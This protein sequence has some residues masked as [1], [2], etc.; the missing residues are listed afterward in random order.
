[1]ALSGAYRLPQMEAYREL[2]IQSVVRYRIDPPP[3][4]WRSE[5]DG[6]RSAYNS[7]TGL[8][9]R[10]GDEAIE[11]RGFGPFR[12]LVGLFGAKLSLPT[13]DTTMWTAHPARVGIGG[14]RPPWPQ[15]DYLA[16]SYTLPTDS[17][18][19]LAVCPYRGQLD[20]LRDA[21]KAA[22]VKES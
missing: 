16:L 18:Y 13:R 20:V 19:T 17:E 4:T 2:G 14:W 11:V 7:I 5:T 15:T 1:M 6:W 3:M 10:I 21:L 8:R 22:G 12:K 9:L